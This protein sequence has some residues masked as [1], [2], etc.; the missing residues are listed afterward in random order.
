M[1]LYELYR[2]TKAKLDSMEK[3]NTCATDQS[4]ALENDFFELVWENGQISMQGKSSRARKSPIHKSLPSHSLPSHSP[5]TRDKDVGFGVDTR[6]GKLGDLDS[7]LNEIPL[8]VPSDEMN[9]SQ[10]EDM[11][12]WLNYPMGDSLQHEYSFDFTRDVSGVT[13]NEFPAASNNF[14]LIDKRSNG[15]QICK[16]SHKSPMPGVS[17]SEQANL[18]KG[19]STGEVETSGLKGNNSQLYQPSSQQCQTS[20]APIRSKISDITENNTSNAILQAPCGEITQIPSSSNGFCSLNMQKQD[21]LCPRNSSN[22]MNFSHFARPAAI[23]R[24]NLQSISMM[25]GLSSARSES[26]GTR[27]KDID[28]SSSNPPES[29]LVDLNNQKN[30]QKLDPSKS[31]LKPANPKSLGQKADFAKQF[32]PACKEDDAFKDDQISKQV[33]T[34]SGTKGLSAVEKTINAEVA[35]SSIC[36]GNAMKRG[37]DDANKNLKRKSQDTEDSECQSEEVEEE[38]VDIK[39]AAPPR[40]TSSKRSRAAEVHNLS[41]RRRR[42]RINEKMRALQELI[43]NCNKVDKASMLD[44]A[45][46]YLKTLQL[47]VQIMSMGAGLYASPNPMMLHPGM[48]HMQT[49]HMASFSPIGIGMQMGLGM[50]YGMGFPDMNSGSPRFPM[51]QVPQMQGTHFPV[52]PMPGPSAALHG[53]PTSSPQAFGFPGPGIYMPMPNAPRVSMPGGP[54]MNPST[55]GQNAFGAAGPGETADSASPSSLKDPM[56]NVNSQVMPGSGGSNSTMQMSTQCEATNVETDQRALV[57]T[58]GHTSSINDSGA[59]NPSKEHDHVISK[60]CKD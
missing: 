31:E 47:Q 29:T 8:P 18:T 20:F 23:V 44:E 35:S 50:G 36:S 33:P 25:S 21:P 32:D 2:M 51:V 49:P 4:S 7:G 46:E 38:S 12:S 52:L 39:K 14:A 30:C 41:E 9:L 6:M 37:S 28:A 13:V 60:S 54:L 11:I 43:P 42:D 40:G 16:D 10:D 26:L 24:A 59:T 53:M 57:R 19:S 58:G 17:N 45:I 5:R 56:P 15:N 22:M 1:P 48:Q 3:D 55:S 34:E 27:K